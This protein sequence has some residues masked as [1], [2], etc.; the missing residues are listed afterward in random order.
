MKI[1]SHRGNISG[2]DPE[3]ENHPER[4]SPNV[5]MRPLYQ[6]VILPN[7][8]YVGGGGEMAYWLELKSYF[9]SVDIP[10]PILLLSGTTFRILQIH[11][12]V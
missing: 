5:I 6:E 3:L 4:F 12:A 1:I 2:P 8:C 9:E 10:F 7:L 11:Q